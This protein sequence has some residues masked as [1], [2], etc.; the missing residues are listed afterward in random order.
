MKESKENNKSNQENTTT[1][2]TV[3]SQDVLS[4]PTDAEVAELTGPVWKV[5]ESCYRA[6]KKD[7]RINLGEQEISYPNKNLTT[8]Y[9]DKGTKLE[10]QALSY[11]ETFITTFYDEKGKPFEIKSYKKDGSLNYLSTNSYNENGLLIDT[12]SRYADGRLLSKVEYIFDEKG[13]YIQ[14]L[15]YHGA[16][17]KLNRKTTFLYDDNGF[18][19]EDISTD[20]DGNLKHRNTYINNQKGHCVEMVMFNGDGSIK[21]S[22]QFYDSYDSDG[23]SIYANNANQKG[24]IDLQDYTFEYDAHGNWIAKIKHYKNN[25][26]NIY[27]R[28]ITYIGEDSTIT[29]EMIL[30]KLNGSSEIIIPKDAESSEIILTDEQTRWVSDGGTAEIFSIA[31]YYLAANNEIP[32]ETYFQLNMLEVASLKKQLIEN[33]GAKVI[34][35]Y[36]VEKDDDEKGLTHYTLTFPNRHFMLH[37][38]GIHRS[39]SYWYDVPDFITE[40]NRYDRDVIFTCQNVRLFHPVADSEFEDENFMQ[41]LIGYMDMCTLERLPDQPEIYMIQESDGEYTLEG[42]EVKDNFVIKDLDLNYG[43]GFTNFHNDLMKRFESETKGL[44]L[45]HGEPGTGKTYYI[46][47][48]LKKMSDS[49][50]IVIYMPPNMVDHLVEPDFMTFLSHEII[51]YSADEYFCVLLIEDA[52]PLL[53]A[54]QSETRIQGVTNLLNLTDGLLNDMLNLQ[55]ICTFNVPLKKLDKA[56]LRPGR[57]IARKEFKALPTLEANIL[58][59]RLGIKY[60][61][62]K[63]A[64]LAE[65]YAMKRNKQTLVHDVDNTNS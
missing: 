13:N 11:G 38:E 3:K 30:E 42:H 37:V 2:E 10:E 7:G 60:E 55:I 16:D 49:K 41:E 25:V 26:T 4:K 45:F 15:Q 21:S 33:M 40:D 52:E 5:K 31:R 63:S 36:E 50:K 46:R 39:S 1:D 22:H 20:G 54:R 6:S 24:N 35:Q 17:E 14:C 57:L 64:S 48:L 58:A 65:I 28:E 29:N 12:T 19:I 51:N 53:A 8:T 47:H 59:S 61:F 56:L 27:L 43:P 44:V 62:K 18:K 9:N 34:H 23:D 32:S